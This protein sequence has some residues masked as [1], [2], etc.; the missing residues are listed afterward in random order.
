M[1]KH[2]ILASLV[3]LSAVAGAGVVAADHDHDGDRDWEDDEERYEESE[4]D[5]LEEKFNA[6]SAYNM[7]YNGTTLDYYSNANITNSSDANITLQL[8]EGEYSYKLNFTDV[9]NGT[10]FIPFIEQEE[11]GRPPFAGADIYIDG[12]EYETVDYEVESEGD[13]DDEDE[14]S[15]LVFPLKGGNETVTIFPD[16]PMP[17]DS[18]PGKRFGNTSGIDREDAVDIREEVLE[19]VEDLTPERV[20]NSTR[21]SLN[22]TNTTNVTVIDYGSG[23]LAYNLSNTN[24][25]STTFYIKASMVENA[26]GENVSDVE[27]RLDDEKIHFSNTTVNGTEWV[28]FTVDH[29]STRQATFAAEKSGSDSGGTTASLFGAPIIVGSLFGVPFWVLV[30]GLLIVAGVGYAAWKTQQDAGVAYH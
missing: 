3:L 8:S 28:A 24:N 1:R 17:Y 29:F 2:V 16:G 26:T 27:L 15:Y 18:F 20:R 10:Y 4:I 22:Q 30:V 25:V 6:S 5:G 11:R 23:L 12:K 9:D 13:G 7:S 21:T 14:R 19:D